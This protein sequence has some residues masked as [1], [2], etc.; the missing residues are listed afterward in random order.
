[1]KFRILNESTYRYD[2]HISLSQH[3]IYLRPRT[4]SLQALTSFDLQISPDAVDSRMIDSLG[5]DL[6]IAR[7][8]DLSDYISIR[9]LA[10]VESLN[11]NPFD[12]VLSDYAMKFPFTYDPVIDAGLAPY[13][14]QPSGYAL[15]YMKQWLDTRFVARP[16]DTIEFLTALNQLIFDQLK[17]VRREEPGIQTAV[18]TLK[19]GGG[20]CRD[21]AVLLMEL[22]RSL[23]VAARFVSGYLYAP[24][25]ENER[26][27]GAMHAWTELYL[28]GAGW[29]GFDPTHGVWCGDR[30]IPVAHGVKAEMAN[31]VQGSYFNNAPVA[32]RLEATVTI[33]LL[34]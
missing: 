13:L 28:P 32:S 11:A 15:S 34:T 10:E 33:D 7:F 30:F 25:S 9:A 26:S 29:R 18:E 4:N 20:T 31:P 6:W 24:D 1:M 5:N 14:L 23:G 12:F 3:R 19:L 17:Y 21:Y 22:A 2:D 27:Y 16:S 8:P